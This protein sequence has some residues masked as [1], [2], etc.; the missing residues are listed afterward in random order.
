MVSA[1]DHS[2]Q[3]LTQ[4]LRPQRLQMVG[5]AV[6]LLGGIGLQILNPQIVRYFIDTAV[7]G[8]A[9]GALVGAAL[10]FIAVAAVRQGLA[11]A[12]TY[13]S[14][15][16]SWSVTNQL[17]LDLA[18]HC[19]KL[20]LAFHKAHTSGELVERVDGDVDALSRFFSQFVIQVVGNVLLLLGVV[21]VLFLED[22]RAGLALGLFALAALGVLSG[23]RAVAVRPWRTYR[24]V[25]AEFYG[26]VVEHLSGREDIRA[27][28]AVDYVMARFYGLLQSWL[29][30]FQQARFSS[31]LLWGSSVGLF[32]VGNAIAL[33]LGAYLWQQNAITVGTVY[34][35]FDYTNLLQEPIERIREELEQLQ[36]AEASLQRVRDLLAQQPQ[37]RSEGQ[38]VLP[39]SALSVT[40]D[41]VWFRYPD[42]SSGW[43]LQDLTFD[44][45]AGQVLGLLG[46]TGSGK[47][48]LARLLLRLYE[49]QQGSIR[50][51][52]LELN[53]IP[54]AAL[55]Q[56][57]GLV[58]QDVQLF[59]TTVR[60]NLTFFSPHVDDAALL[61]VLDDLGLRP[62][63][64]SLPQGL[65]TELG[66]D[67]GGLS[68]GQAQLL[69]FARVFLKN[70]GLVILD[71]ASSR[72]D[73]QTEL[74]IERAVDRLLAGRT[75]II[76][77]HRLKTIQR[78]DQILIL[79]Q[80][81]ILEAG[82]RD[83]L[84]NQ[85]NSRFAQLLRLGAGA[86][87]G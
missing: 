36:Q 42:E 78:A 53:Q 26:F 63:L 75:G 18:N 41:R 45:P 71:E 49:P 39:T 84:E 86:L 6:T 74:L 34:L 2:A 23:L 38:A 29:P 12:A 30:V 25:T 19:L 33:A 61:T 8:Q 68:A 50:L 46:R 56:Q 66:P 70:P 32:T 64:Q 9:Q 37:Q 43:T 40:F 27:N 1:S 85:P 13:F 21:G 57:V 77:A 69:A 73:P 52:P 24:Q 55:P 20:D 48:T 28:G 3:L 59:Q 67:G 62:W 80:G 47:S 65:D 35:L 17:R 15:T 10:L 87:L 58:T 4:Y 22:W 5:L 31:T 7:A 72:L 79:D 14:E 81:Q 76:I 11:I 82:R 16:V 51:G 54:L 83:Q 44:L 60:H